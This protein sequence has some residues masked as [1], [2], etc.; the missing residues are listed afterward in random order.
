MRLRTRLARIVLISLLVLV[1]A[2]YFAFSTFVFSPTEADYDADIAT[3]I[4]RDVDFYLAKSDLRADFAALPR[5]AIQDQLDK[6]SGWRTWVDSPEYKQLDE[7][8]GIEAALAQIEREVAALGIDPLKA[9]GGRELALAGYFRGARVEDSDWA[10]LGR[11]SWM[12]KLAVAALDFPGLVGLDA[13]GLSVSSGD[14]I[15]SITGAQLPR[16]LHVTRVLDVVVVG[17]SR[18]LAAKARELY[19]RAGQESFGLSANFNDHIAQAHRTVE[20]DDLELYVDWRT[21]AEK[22]RISGRFPDPQ[23]DSPGMA[24]VARAFQLGLL[25][26]LA[27]TVG[28]D[29]GV[30]V[31]AHGELSSETMTA[32]QKTLYR[33]RGRDSKGIVKDL[34]RIARPDAHLVA[35][36]EVDI[37]EF[38]TE[39]YSSLEP[40]QRQ[41][42]DDTL[43]STG[44]YNGTPAFIKE[45]ETLFKGRIGLIARDNDYPVSSAENDPPHND[46]PV[47]AMTFVFWTVGTAKAHE[48]IAQLQK[49]VSDNQ[50]KFG[51][52]GRSGKGGV[53]IHNLAGGF[54]AWE[55]WSPFIDGTGHIAVARDNELYFL[56]NSYALVSDLLNRGN[57]E[58]RVERLSDRPEFTQLVNEGLQASNAFIWFN[59]RATAKTLRAFA[60][61][62]ALDEIRSRIETTVDWNLERAREED[63]VLRE[64]FPGKRRGQL[65][66]DTQRQLDEIVQPLLDA[67]E[68]TLIR[69]QVPALKAAFER[70]IKYLEMCSAALLTI[71]LDPKYFDLALSAIVPLD[72]K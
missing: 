28:F 5:L 23:A 63:R 62:N 68:Q 25:R 37:G 48:R 50:G 17:T 57:P 46:V 58:A 2:G 67:R 61:Y 15:A 69:E 72:A 13:R 44:Q 60:D 11:V 47:P 53:F 42:L 32:F 56:S 12:G 18:D 59:P 31:D 7:Q 4:P 27:G 45:L 30:M 41:L 39:L 66:A 14:G 38:L 24:F 20:G 16:P 1:F 65:D 55:Y 71:Q 35:H 6:T 29:R 3:L 33:Q 43:R 40:A 54:E 36:L 26:S 34:A 64:Q 8:Y 10:V 70:Q 51:L 19:A 22:L 9:F 21:A 49:L 52:K